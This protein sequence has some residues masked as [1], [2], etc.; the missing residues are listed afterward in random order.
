MH[1]NPKGWTLIGALLAITMALGPLTATPILVH[2]A[3]Q[4]PTAIT[5]TTIADTLYRADGSTASGTLVISWPQ[6]ITATGQSVQAGTIS[7]PI[8]AGVLNVQ[9]APNA[10]SNPMG[11]YYTV[12]YHLDDGSTS[13]EYWVVPTTPAPVTIATIRSTVLPASVAMQTASVS[14]VNSAIAAA[15]G[16]SATDPTTPY[17]LKTGD[18][19]TGPLVLPDDPVSANQAADKHYVDTALAATTG[20]VGQKVSLTPQTT[21][22]IVQPAGTEL[23]VNYMNG[24]QYATQYVAGQGNNGIANAA[25]SADCANGCELAVGNDYA[26]SEEYRSASL[27]NQTHIVDTRLGA[28]AD[29]YINPGNVFAPGTAVG[30]SID[31]VSTQN[32]GIANGAVVTEDPN[33]V[34]L[35]ISIEGEA[36]GSNL[37]PQTPEGV[38]PYFKSNYVAESISGTFNTLGQHQLTNQF[39]SCYG[40]GDCLIGAQSIVSSGGFRDEADEGAHPFDLQYH[41]D[42]QVFT[43]TCTTGCT[44]GSTS[45][46]VGS[47]VAP[48]TQGEGR[49]LIDRSPSKILS[50][51]LLTGG[52]NGAPYSSASF[53]GTSFPLSVFFLTAQLAPSQ[54]NNVAPGTVTL[55]IQTGSVPTGFSISTVAAPATHGVACV[56]DPNA[57]GGPL[58]HNYEMANYTVVDGSHLQ[59]TLNKVHAPGSTIAIGGLCGYGLEQ[60]IDTASGIRQVFPVVGSFSS[61]GLY[62]A[63]SRSAVVGQMGQTSGFMNVLSNVA[64]IARTGNLVT[65]TSAGNFPQDINGLS[66]TVAGVTDSSYNG[67][68]TVTTTGPN[69][70]TYTQ[71]GADS[72]STSGT[73]SRLTGGYTL[74]PMAE[75]L[76]VLNPATKMI[77]GQMALAP[78]TVAWAAGDPLEEPHYFQQSVSPDGASYS[79][80]MPRPASAFG[81]GLFYSGNNGPGLTG[82]QV[83]N[84]TPASSYF[85][86]GGSHAPPTTGMAIGGVWDR[87]MVIDPGV[88]GV[89]T[90]NC[91]LHGCNRWNSG[92]DVFQFTSG[93]GADT[94]HYQPQTS[95]LNFFLRGSGYSF[96]PQAFTAATINATTLNATTIN[97]SVSGNAITSGAV[98]AQFLPLLGASGSVHAAG[99]VPDP[100][101][102][103]GNTRYLREDGTWAA[104]TAVSTGGNLVAGATADFNFLEGSGTMLLDTTG[105]G[106]N[107]TFVPGASPTWTPT[108]LAFQPLQGVSLPAALNATQTFFTAIYINPITAGPQI[109][110]L[111]PV[112]LSSSN[113]ATGF[114][115]MVSFYSPAGQNFLQNAYAPTLYVN[116]RP[117]TVTPNLFSGF[118]VLA[119]VLGSGSGST[120]HVYIDGSEVASYLTQGTSAGAQSAGNLFLGTS[121]AAPWQTSGFYGTLYR[122]RT[123][124]TQLSAAAVQSVS[125]SMAYEIASRGVVITPVP[126]PLATPQFHAIGDS[127]TFGQGVAT[128]WPSLLTLA[129]QPAYSITDWGITGITLAAINGSES[130]R[131]ALRCHSTAGPQIAVVFAGTND[132]GLLTTSAASVF[133]NLMGEVQTMK[134]AGCRVFVGTM[135]SR[136]GNDPSG[137][138]LDTDK[139][140]YDALILSQ[141]RAGGADGIIDFAANPLL[142]ADNANAGTFFQGDQIHPTQAGQALLAAAASNVLNFTF[143]A[144]EASPHVVTTLGYAMVAADGYVSLAGLTNSGTL[145]L[146]DCTGPSGVSYRI[147]NPQSA[148]AVTVAPLNGSQLING[149]STLTIPANAT[150]TLRDVPNPKAVSGCHWEQ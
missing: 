48:G 105:N 45:L 92:Y 137:N 135:L 55:P 31:L 113:G 33:T 103:S 11:S 107:G 85:G 69:V 68:F 80:V 98:G 82:W 8:V 129:N 59:M 96:T 89:F 74:Y 130:N 18:T 116:N 108:G 115:L 35:N 37:F 60:T 136:T 102:V 2:A 71:T 126:V 114:N 39:I 67:T 78:N 111:Y 44:T 124:P 149:L 118:H 40:V 20:G 145:T 36:G 91:N 139:D 86:A 87:S 65:L 110:N 81:G 122:M 121:G 95:N 38:V 1:W 64:A 61:T 10:G 22:V 19:M 150:L 57:G 24:V 117:A 99:I 84:G 76:G 120:D 28:R 90:L 88:T 134:Q 73:V 147:N 66:M 17:V 49:Y 77:D 42:A 32:R 21:Q 4:S 5:T 141:A 54:A 34:A 94:I 7:A 106:N 127:I 27:N 123:Y 72:T 29:S 15:V 53:S 132:F 144:N 148:F 25:A 50:S 12:M 52:L 70:L 93:V 125:A 14:Y 109:G 62:Y 51:G 97:G 133:T 13:R 3:A 146:P 58:P 79:Q 43:G 142:G 75:V 23:Q 143:G 128:P 9:L 101:A 112:L 6:F 56:V 16:S 138:S 47:V 119:V 26:S 140:N 46:M 104:P 83:G 131:A 63:A 100:G 30:Q 41:E